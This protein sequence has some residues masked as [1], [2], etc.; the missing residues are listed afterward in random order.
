MTFSGILSQLSAFLPFGED[1]K[2]ASRRKYCESSVG[3]IQKKTESYSFSFGSYKIA[4][5]EVCGDEVASF[6]ANGKK[7]ALIS[8]GMGTGKGANALAKRLCVI[9][10]SLI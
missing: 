5:E 10:Q 3:A 1:G 7:Y 2:G 6:E 9:L 4:K 8:D